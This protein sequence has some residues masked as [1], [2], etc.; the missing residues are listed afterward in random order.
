M[1]I[2]PEQIFR[3]VKATITLYDERI[4]N[5]IIPNWREAFN[6][7]KFSFS[8]R[9]KLFL[10]AQLSQQMA[11]NIVPTAGLRQVC[12]AMAGSST[13]IGKIAINYG[14]LGT[15]STAA[16]LGDTQ[17]GAETFR[18][19]IAS[20]TFSANKAYYTAFYTA[21][22]VSGT[23]EEIG[24]FINGGPLANSGILWSHIVQQIVKT[25]VQTLTIDYEDT[26]TN[27]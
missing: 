8:E 18:K 20:K 27:G 9:H 14:A 24:L 13:S 16:A 26:F 11:A 5:K 15:S 22:E 12:R 6:L 10:P 23:F 2:T 17:L 3:K 1:I 25:A 4:L 21:D 19:A 7:K